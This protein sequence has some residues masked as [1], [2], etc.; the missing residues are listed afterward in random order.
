M[1]VQKLY[2]PVNNRVC[3]VFVTLGVNS[4]EKP[5]THCPA[6]SLYLAM[7]RPVGH[8]GRAQ[9]PAPTMGG[10]KFRDKNFTHPQ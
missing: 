2:T 9:R 5:L 6:G 3:K 7:P 10:E 8:N 1:F 4:K